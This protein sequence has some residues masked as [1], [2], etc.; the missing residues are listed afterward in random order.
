MYG[1]TDGYL[2]VVGE[3]EPYH[4][5]AL[6]VEAEIGIGG[7]PVGRCQSQRKVLRKPRI[8]GQ[9]SFLN[10]HGDLKILACSHLVGM[11]NGQFHL[12]TGHGQSKAA[13]SH[14][15]EGENIFFHS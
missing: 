7:T 11:I 8:I 9:R 5:D 6:V 14:E 4:A 2:R 3:L 10:G 1:I 12:L 13:D 15:Y